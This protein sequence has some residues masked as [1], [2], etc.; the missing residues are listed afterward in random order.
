MTLRASGLGITG[1]LPAARKPRVRSGLHGDLFENHFR[2]S[3]Q[4]PR[5]TGHRIHT[6]AISGFCGKDG[7]LVEFPAPARKRIQD[8]LR[9][10][11]VRLSFEKRGKTPLPQ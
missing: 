4:A 10:F 6:E 8:S 11:E 9:G 2:S 7:G 1:N 5:N 3:G